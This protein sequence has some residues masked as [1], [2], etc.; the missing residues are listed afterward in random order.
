M[1]KSKSTAVT[2][3]DH[4]LLAQVVAA[5]EAGG[6]HY[7]SQPQGQPMLSHVPPLIMV[8]TS[9]LD[10]NDGTKAAAKAT[11][12][13]K[14]YLAANGKAAEWTAPATEGSK[15]AILTGVVLPEPK[16]R[17][18]SFGSG[19]PTKYPFADMPIGGSFFSANSEHKKGDAVKALGSTVSSQNRKYA[20][21]TNTQKT[22]TRA[23]RDKKTHKAILNADGS[24][25]TETVT[26]P[27]LSYER[28]FTIRP[29][30]GGQTYGSW[31]APEDGALV[32]R[33]K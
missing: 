16:K 27:V 22:V 30:T 6:H 7:V 19:A 5:T 15:Y 21:E 9:M 28:K 18:N 32:A 1:A 11:E 17:G 13:A 23:I 3:V 14:A 12:H 25:Q 8:N 29:V 4:Q 31:V 33:I 10:P 24:K 26:L 2:G 20:V